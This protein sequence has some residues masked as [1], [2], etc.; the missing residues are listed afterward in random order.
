MVL[1][2]RNICFG[3]FDAEEAFKDLPEILP[4]VRGQGARHILPHSPFR[5]LSIGRIPHFL[6]DP[7]GLI[8]QA[9]ARAFKAA[10][11]P[12]NGE[13][14]ARRAKRD[15]VHGLQPRAGQA[16]D[17][18]VTLH[19]GQ[20]LLRYPYGE[21]LD[22]RRPHGLHTRI[23]AGQ[24]ETADAVKETAQCHL[25]RRFHHPPFPPAQVLPLPPPHRFAAPVP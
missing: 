3:V 11:F 2:Q 24:R 12:G 14:L 23:D 25:F 1:R 8:K 9:G 16:M 22:L 6:Y 17:I 4:I 7:H 21:R 10:A 13:I 19:A 18:A 15:H 5:V 20:P